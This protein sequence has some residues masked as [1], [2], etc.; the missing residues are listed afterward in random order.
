MSDWELKAAAKTVAEYMCNVQRGENVLIYCDTLVEDAVADSIAEAVH[1]AGGAV[2]LYR[3]ETRPQVDLEPPSPLAAAMKASDVMIELAWKYLIHTR[4][5]EE[6]LKAGTRYACLTMITADIMKRC[7][8]PIDYYAAVLDFGEAITKLLEATSDMHVTTPAGTDLVCNIEGRLIDHASKRIYGPSEQT[9]PGGQISWYPSA[10]S[11]Q[12]TMVFDGSMWPPEN[13]GLIQEPIRL[14]IKDGRVTDVQGGNEARILKRWFE[15]FDNPHIYDLAHI[16]YGVNPGAQLTGNILEDE[17]VFGCVEVGIGA[18]PP[19]LGIFEV[20]P[21]EAVAGHTDAI[22]LNPTVTL[23]GV[24]IEK[25]GV[26]QH[27][28]L[29][30]I[31]ERF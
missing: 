26:F 22:M 16:S 12:G 1:V 24:I 21:A 31:I 15:S 20:D 2:A 28:E 3:Y 4:A 23:D 10:E 7:I 29:L 8:G 25:D 11:I 5:L 9:Y 14:T 19:A 6:A 30:S 17:R 13:I 18:Q 27:P